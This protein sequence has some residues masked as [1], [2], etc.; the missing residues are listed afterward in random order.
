MP[1]DEWLPFE[2]VKLPEE[3]VSPFDLNPDVA[4]RKKVVTVQFNITDP[5]F[6][7]RLAWKDFLPFWPKAGSEKTT[8]LFDLVAAVDAANAVKGQAYD[9]D[10]LVGKKGRLMMA[11]Y[12]SKKRNADGTAIIKQKVDRIL[13]LASAPATTAA[14]AVAATTT[15][16]V[17]E[18][19]V[20]GGT[21]KRVRF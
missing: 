19:A 17:V 21:K 4:L 7:N 6:A 16:A 12:E 1:I 5:R 13:P 3:K 15:A 11:N 20:S 9:T 2:I 8:Q 14:P 18:E 10:Q